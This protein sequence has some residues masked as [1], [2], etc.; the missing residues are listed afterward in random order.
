WTRKF[1]PIDFKEEDSETKP[2]DPPKPPKESPNSPEEATETGEDISSLPLDLQKIEKIE[3]P[4]EIEKKILSQEPTREAKYP[5]E[6]AC[7]FRQKIAKMLQN[8]RFFEAIEQC[9]NARAN[10]M[11][12]EYQAELD[13]MA[14]DL[15][16]CLQ[17][18]QQWIEVLKDPSALT[19]KFKLI[20]GLKLE[21]SVKKF[22]QKLL[23]VESTQG[24][25]GINIFMLSTETLI[26]MAKL[27]KLPQLEELGTLL[28]FWEGN[29]SKAGEGFKSHND[30][31]NATTYLK[32]L[33]QWKS[34][35][36]QVQTLE[37]ERSNQFKQTEKSYDLFNQVLEE[38]NHKDENKALYEIS[39]LCPLLTPETTQEMEELLKKEIK[40]DW[41]QLISDLRYRCTTCNEDRKLS[42]TPCN[43]KGR[44][45]N[46]PHFS[47]KPDSSGQFICP[48]CKGQGMFTCGACVWRFGDPKAQGVEKYFAVPSATTE[49]KLYS[50]LQKTVITGEVR[51][52]DLLCEEFNVIL[53][54]TGANHGKE[55]KAYQTEVQ[56]G[57]YFQFE[58]PQGSYSLFYWKD[59]VVFRKNIIADKGSLQVNLAIKST[60]DF[61]S[62]EEPNAVLTRPPFLKW[63]H[64]KE[65]HFVVKVFQIENS[66]SFFQYKPI[67]IFYQVGNSL[68]IPKKEAVLGKTYLVLIHGYGGTQLMSQ[69]RTTFKVK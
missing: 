25:M 17:L 30:F 8:R 62:P 32:K 9:K 51:W 58:V 35:E 34:H 19:L 57:S 24:T 15:Q 44:T 43:G 18:Y 49:K 53:I 60:I 54:G 56:S 68:L 69:G 38:L 14:E 28:A 42:C 52:G 31:K 22:D 11:N 6:T 36:K 1:A 5:L 41:I 29:A 20:T 12:L 21:G 47:A 63:T 33:E 16:S 48:K 40:K 67:A 23:H 3:P 13:G 4:P 27:K 10:A 7:Y 64:N 50:P 46:P 61:L 2:E 59:T 37:K 66:K 55:G 39:K 26:E 65:E 45:K